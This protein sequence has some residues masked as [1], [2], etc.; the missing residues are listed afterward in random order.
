MKKNLL[1]TSLFTFA[2]LAFV[3]CKN[4]ENQADVSEAQ[5]VAEVEMAATY[6]ADTAASVVEWIGSKPTGTHHGTVQLQ[7]GTFMVK[8]G[9]IAGGT[10]MI[11]MNTITDLD[12]EGDMKSNLEAHL[13]GTVEGKEGDFF[14]VTQYPT[15]TFEITEVK[16]QE[17]K[18]MVSGNL[19]M[20]EKTHNVTF[21]ATISMNGDVVQLESE[22]FSIDRTLWDVNYGSKSVFDN[23]GDKFINDEIE[24]TIK[25]T[26][27]KEAE[28]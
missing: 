14:N 15:A 2:V 3:S 28:A 6:N 16:E 4:N 1:K 25:V 11:D 24:L 21:P 17:G 19:T 27:N 22:T 9:S 20:K 18:T 23:L 26:A 8:D 5:E 12:L 10:F 7:D 13:K